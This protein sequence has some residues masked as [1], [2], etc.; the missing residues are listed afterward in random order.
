MKTK[1]FDMPEKLAEFVNTNNIKKESIVAI[2]GGGTSYI[3][4]FYYE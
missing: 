3:Y 1:A 4:L 2:I